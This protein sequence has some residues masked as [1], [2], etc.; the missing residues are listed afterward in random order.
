MSLWTES[1]VV[2]NGRQRVTWV[3][4][5]VAFTPRVPS[6]RL[7][8]FAQCFVGWKSREF[9]DEIVDDLIIS[10]IF[11]NDSHFRW[12]QL[13]KLTMLIICVNNIFIILLSFYAYF[14]NPWCSHQSDT[15]TSSSRYRCDRLASPWLAPN[16]YYEM[17]SISGLLSPRCRCVKCLSITH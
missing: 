9:V 16:D 10:T 6:S 4:V 15:L 17:L 14:R 5:F 3:F 11:A 8:C 7:A 12:I 2:F 1:N 13:N